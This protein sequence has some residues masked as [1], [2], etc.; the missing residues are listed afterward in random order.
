[1]GRPRRIGFA[2]T[3]GFSGSPP[4]GVTLW[5]VDFRNLTTFPQG[6]MSPSAFAAAVPAAPGLTF[7]DAS[8]GGSIYSVQTSASSLIVGIAQGYARFGSF[9]DATREG[10]A[11]EQASTNVIPATGLYAT[12]NGQTVTAG[13]S[14]PAGGTTATHIQCASGNV[15][16]S[17]TGLYAA[18]SGLTYSFSAWQQQG[19]VGGTNSV[20]LA[21]SAAVQWS[22][23]SSW[24]RYIPTTQGSPYY[25][26]YTSPSGL[27]QYIF[28]VNGSAREGVPAAS[29]DVIQY[30]VQWEPSFVPTSYI[31]A[32]S[33]AASRAAGG[34]QVS[35]PSACV[36]ASGRVNMEIM[37]VPYGPM[38][39]YDPTH[40][41][42]LF[43]QPSGDN[44]SIKMPSGIISVTCGGVTR[45]LGA[46]AWYSLGDIIDI[47]VQ[48]GGGSI[49]TTGSYLY[50]PAGSNTSQLYV[51]GSTPDAQ[52]AWLATGTHYIGGDGTNTRLNAMLQKVAFYG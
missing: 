44:I 10:L 33:A 40:D 24:A 11:L 35:A 23:T 7:S 20:L 45:T 21:G 34:L 47:N 6:G 26:P 28:P 36:N 15:V 38:S 48:A 16:Y 37:F 3:L 13:Q 43:G 5:S 27:S 52:P 9:S 32:T 46:L 4:I 50:T 17:A 39:A 2:E 18:T 22:L 31:H 14:D 12:A 51:L 42:V 8:S 25:Y 30:G 49:V 19:S 1:V 41:I 29:R